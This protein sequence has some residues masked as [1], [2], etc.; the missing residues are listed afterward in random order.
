[1]PKWP[2]SSGPVRNE[3]SCCTAMD[4][5]LCGRM[6][7]TDRRASCGAHEGLDLVDVFHSRSAL[8]TGRDIDA[9]CTGNAQRFADI[10]GIE[11]AG[12]HEGHT[13][14]HVLKKMPIERIAEAAGTGGLPRRAR[15]E[16]QAVGDRGI[17]R[18]ALEIVFDGN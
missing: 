16:Q 11:P 4:D 10:A 1:M 6:N 18:D 7:V 17:S 5:S 2:C 13:R 12:Q 8:E 14:L 3:L 15:I 9:R